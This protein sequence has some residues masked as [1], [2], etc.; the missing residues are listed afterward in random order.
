MVGVPTLCRSL[1]F[2]IFHSVSS[3]PG[4]ILTFSVQYILGL[5]LTSLKLKI[6]TIQ[7]LEI[8]WNPSWVYQVYSIRIRSRDSRRHE[9]SDIG[10]LH[11][12]NLPSCLYSYSGNRMSTLL[13]SQGDDCPKCNMSSTRWVLCCFVLWFWSFHS[14][15]RPLP[16]LPHP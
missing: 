9:T 14:V 2:T 15:S 5:P 3:V 4:L 6:R 8:S 16:L 1:S 10:V 13:V 11:L 12:V 7:L